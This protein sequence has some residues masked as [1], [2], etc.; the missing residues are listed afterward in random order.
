MIINFSS[1]LFR[2]LYWL[3]YG[4]FPMIGRAYLDGSDW[5]P[6]VTTRISNPRDLTVDMFTHDVYW[7]D[8]T[9]DAINKVKR[10]YHFI[11]QH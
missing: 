10:A 11:I 9:L 7:V 4:Q 5:K 2:Y 1:V 3:D 6:L 8:S